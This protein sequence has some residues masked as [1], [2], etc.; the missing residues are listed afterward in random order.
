MRRLRIKSAVFLSPLV[1]L[2]AMYIV[3]DPFQD[4]PFHQLHEFDIQMLSRG[5]ISVKMYLKNADKYNYDSFIFGSSRATSSTAAEWKRYLP[6]NS[7][8]FSFGAWNES[9]KGMY[10]RLKLIDSLNHKINNT[11]IVIDLDRSFNLGPITWDHYLIT[12]Q[13]ARDY[14]LNHFY[15]YIQDPKLLLTIIKHT[16]FNQKITGPNFTGQEK[17]DLDLIT[18]D[19][20]LNSD[21]KILADSVN[22]YK[23]SISRFYERS[24]T[25]QL[26]PILI[27]A[28]NK[29][30]L[31]KIAALLQKHH[32][33]NKIVI[34]PIYD[35]VGINPADLNFLGVVFG[36]QNVF[37]FSGIN[38]ITQDIHNYS[39]DVMHYRKKVGNLIFTKVYAGR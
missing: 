29:I 32:S 2:I 19:W 6:K 36:K 37:D 1:A 30:F 21:K 28:K 39:S 3:T 22:Y 7:Q 27:D 14:Y 17:E 16:I 23:N 9:V 33:N 8:P 20:D 11:F 34:S 5:D 18:N 38:E 24:K 10:R 31:L 25:K 12:H 15:T 26:S 35:Q 13:S 4:M